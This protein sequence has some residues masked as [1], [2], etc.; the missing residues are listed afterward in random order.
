MSSLL[1]GPNPLTLTLTMATRRNLTYKE[2]L[3]VLECLEKGEMS[4]AE[5]A[6]SYSIALPTLLRIIRS[7]DSIAQLGNAVGEK[8]RI[9]APVYGEARIVWHSPCA[10]GVPLLIPRI[11]QIEELLLVWIN[12]KNLEGTKVTGRMIKDRATEI[13]IEIQCYNFPA[14]NGWLDNFRKRYGFNKNNEITSELHSRPTESNGDIIIMY[15]EPE[16]V[17]PPKKR[18]PAVSLQQRDK[19]QV[20]ILKEESP[21]RPGGAVVKQEQ[22]L[23]FIDIEEGG[24]TYVVEQTEFV[25]TA[26]YTREDAREAHQILIAYFNANTPPP[27]TYLSLQRIGEAIGDDPEVVEEEQQ[28][29]EEDLEADV[30]G[31]HLDDQQEEA[32]IEEVELERGAGT[33][34]EI[35]V[36]IEESFLE[37]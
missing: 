10:S 33:D 19:Q 4:R 20:Y 12:Q 3:G 14:S 9:R 24:D 36:E 35:E 18:R 22:E 2:K 26:E 25:E 5:I 13:A 27:G 15:N 30:E 16:T 28:E 21:Q 32:I 29:V 7:R 23:E 11:F 1:P 8:T 17:P 37:E 34:G 6:A 31:P